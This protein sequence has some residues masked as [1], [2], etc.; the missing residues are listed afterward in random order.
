MFILFQFAVPTIDV[1]PE[2][3]QSSHS[4][5]GVTF[6]W[7]PLP[8]VC[9]PCSMRS[10]KTDPFSN[11]T[12]TA[13]DMEVVNDNETHKHGINQGLTKR[14]YSATKSHN[15]SHK[16]TRQIQS[17]K[18]NENQVTG[19]SSDL[20]PVKIDPKTTTSPDFLDVR[21]IP[22]NPVNPHQESEKRSRSNKTE[23]VASRV[24]QT[25]EER[26]SAQGVEIPSES[27]SD[28]EDAC[29]EV[30]SSAKKLECCPLCQTIF[31]SG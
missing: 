6:K 29:N 25:H 3:E 16:N 14:P 19:N 18:I 31:H 2:H 11:P 7:R 10:Y 23:V 4:V 9:V 15:K 13:E 26:D 27:P 22:E 1:R 8:P 12:D 17:D 21:N 28:L 20:L 5:C 24:L 30:D